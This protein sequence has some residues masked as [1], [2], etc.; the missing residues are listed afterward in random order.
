MKRSTNATRHSCFRLTLVGLVL[1]AC[2]VQ[3]H[4]HEQTETGA[5]GS[6]FK[7]PP[8]TDG[9]AITANGG[10][11]QP[12]N[13]GASSGGANGGASFLAGGSTFGGASNGGVAGSFA[14]GGTTGVAGATSVAGAAAG[15]TPPVTSGGR[16]G[17]TVDINGTVL[18]KE[19]VIAFV[20]I[21]HSNMLGYGTSP[22]ASRAYH[23]S[24]VNLRAW[25]YKRG[26]WSPA[27]E[28]TAGAGT[29]NAGPGTSLLKQAVDLAPNRYFVSLG[30]GVGSAYCSQFLRGGLYYNEIMTAPLALKGKVTFGAILIMLGITERHGTDQD[31]SNFPNCI[32]EVVTAIRTDLAEPNLPVLL[33]D[34]EMGATGSELSPTGAFGTKMIPKIREVPSVVSRSAIVP[35][36]GLGM[37]DDHHFNLD[38]QKEWSK[39]A[40][41]IMKDKGW[42]LW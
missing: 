32:N 7:P 8:P 31:I 38:G 30:Y 10:V 18:P 15:G 25:Q 4:P 33:C 6:V 41:T 13:G 24:E 3:E 37:Q 20:H 26:A 19:D 11:G 1:A 17:A 22:S 36:D 9:G 42:F 28:R 29:N 23:L 34:Y 39:R 2:G 5:G 40:L 16:S 27:L 14:R 12:A 35:T 21:G